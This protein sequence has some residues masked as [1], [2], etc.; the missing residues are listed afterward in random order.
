[1]VI[2]TVTQALDDNYRKPLEAKT[3]IVDEA[4]QMNKVQLAALWATYKQAHRLIFA[5]DCNQ[6]GVYFEERDGNPVLSQWKQSVHQRFHDLGFPTAHF[7]TQRRCTWD[8][9]QL[10][11]SVFYQEQVVGVPETRE[12][13]QSSRVRVFNQRCFDA[14]HNVVLVDVDGTVCEGKEGGRGRYNKKTA[15]A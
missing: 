4:S 5:G 7:R 8:I 2:L 10:V 15:E 1:M 13:E 3:I 12:R 11:S 6:H 9:A 14:K